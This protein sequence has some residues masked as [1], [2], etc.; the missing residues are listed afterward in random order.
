MKGLYRYKLSKKLAV[1]GRIRNSSTYWAPI[2][3]WARYSLARTEFD[4]LAE[5]ATPFPTTLLPKP[6]RFSPYVHLFPSSGV[7]A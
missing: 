4:P 2:W 7:Y 1:L 5:F 6:N 3:N